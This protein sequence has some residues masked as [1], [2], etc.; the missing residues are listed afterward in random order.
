M[1]DATEKGFGTGLRAQLELKQNGGKQPTPTEERNGPSQEE[2]RSVSEAI[3]LA[4]MQA[5]GD[6]ELRAELDRSLER[7][8]DLRTEHAQQVDALDQQQQL[9]KRVEELDDRAAHLAASEA[10][11]AGR[12]GSA[13]GE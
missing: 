4:T 10:T 3:A 1:A 11:V 8:R 2:A 13:A 12:E 5:E 6:T 9:S 7:V